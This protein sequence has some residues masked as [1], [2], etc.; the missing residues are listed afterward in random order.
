MSWFR[1]AFENP[2]NIVV[3]A[4]ELAQTNR[5]WFFAPTL[6]GSLALWRRETETFNQEQESDQDLNPKTVVYKALGVVIFGVSVK[7]LT[8]RGSDVSLLIGLIVMLFGWVVIT[9]SERD[10]D[11]LAREILGKMGFDRR[12]TF[13]SSAEGWLSVIKLLE[14]MGGEYESE[15]S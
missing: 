1:I 3:L 8:D 2:Q 9:R 11:R 12:V 13:E 4:G 15:R 14:E 7:I 6:N 5:V 10:A